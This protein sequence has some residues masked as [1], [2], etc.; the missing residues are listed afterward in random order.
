MYLT[1]GGKNST[2]ALTK[3]SLFLHF[4]SYNV[5]FPR[6]IPISVDDFLISTTINQ[7]KKNEVNRD[8]NMTRAHFSLHAG[9]HWATQLFTA[10]N[11]TEGRLIFDVIR[12]LGLFQEAL[13][14]NFGLPLMKYSCFLRF[15]RCVFKHLEA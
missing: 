7:W 3:M 12:V 2:P 8:Y 10:Q 13:T 6:Q 1:N 11:I 14:E 9:F 4:I 5:P 15:G